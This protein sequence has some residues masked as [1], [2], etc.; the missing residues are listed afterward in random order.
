MARVRLS[1]KGS[2]TCCSL[3]SE[4]VEMIFLNKWVLDCLWEL[5]HVLAVVASSGLSLGRAQEH[6][7]GS[8]LG[9]VRGVLEKL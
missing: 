8:H 9:L 5:L 3:L 4:F 6:V 1:R 2:G 7:V